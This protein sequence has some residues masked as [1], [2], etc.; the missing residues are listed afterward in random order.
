MDERM[1][2]VR[3]V[4]DGRY[5]Y[6][7][8][9]YP[10][11]SQAQQVA[12]QFVTPTTRVWKTLFDKKKTTPAQ[13]IFWQVPKAPEELYDLQ[14][15]R[16]EVNNLAQSAEHQ[17]IL[18]KLRSALT[19]HL[20]QVRDVCFLPEL[21]MHQRSQGGSPYDMARA[22]AKD[23]LL[24]IQAAAKLASNL[25]PAATPALVK[26]TTDKDSAVRVWG[27]LG[28]HMRGSEVVK[29][30]VEVLAKGLSDDSVTVRIVSAQALG[31]YG[32][33]DAVA[34]ALETLGKLAPPEPNGVL[35]SM[36][37]L[38]A[39]E[40]LGT[41]AQPLHASIRAMNTNGAAPDE[42]YQSYVPRLIENILPNAKPSGAKT[43]KQKNN[44]PTV[45]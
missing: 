27:I 19:T 41:K 44:K 15:D 11:V 45:P 6:L 4:T 14:A 37:A 32:D 3:S 24:R 22:S 23:A 34:K 42:R 7:R 29:R 2:L 9:Y 1:D 28:L 39:I 38:A 26:L 10:H 17:V 13:S 35:T 20:I 43:K 5:V 36:A 25:D 40:A 8:N 33:A 30:H 16:D 18:E 12:Y 31:T 21:E